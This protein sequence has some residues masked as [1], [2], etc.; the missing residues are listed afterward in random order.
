MQ[1]LHDV[2]AKASSFEQQTPTTTADVKTFTPPAGARACLITVET[3]DARISL[4]GTTPSATVG[5][6]LK[7]DQQPLYIPAAVPI[8][9]VST[10]A[11]NAIVNVTW[12]N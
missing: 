2:L 1:A 4:H 7:K 11:G 6:V 5:H 8:K 12:L 10:V 9:A 3:N